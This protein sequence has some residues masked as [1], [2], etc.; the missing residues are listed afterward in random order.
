MPTATSP[1]WGNFGGEDRGVEAR[2][3]TWQQRAGASRNSCSRN[4]SP[5]QSQE[6]VDRMGAKQ[7][8]TGTT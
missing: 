8:E 7:S 1:A 5:G 3:Q 4:M 2:P 6:L